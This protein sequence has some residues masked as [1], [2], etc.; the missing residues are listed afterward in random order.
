L[1]MFG[2]FF[3][4]LKS[5]LHYRKPL[6]LEA[7]DSALERPWSVAELLWLAD[8]DRV[9]KTPRFTLLLGN[10]RGL[11]AGKLTWKNLEKADKLLA[12]RPFD[13]ENV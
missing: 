4:L 11:L 1:L 12:A 2:G 3:Y 9:Q 13:Q 6:C 8:P 10:T 7:L 5:G